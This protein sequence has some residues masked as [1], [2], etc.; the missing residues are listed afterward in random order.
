MLLK[1]NDS[2]MLSHGMV[3]VS[4]RNFNEKL[5]KFNFE[6]EIYII[7]SCNMLLKKMLL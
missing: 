2:N 4:D 1:K 7:R 3:A 5:I 6:I